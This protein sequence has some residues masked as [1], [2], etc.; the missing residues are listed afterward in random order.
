MDAE[1]KQI[2][3]EIKIVGS[4]A[5]TAQ[6]AALGQ[7]FASRT[8][9]AVIAAAMDGMSNEELLATGIALGEAWK[10]E[11][12]ASAAESQKWT[13][14]GM[15]ILVYGLTKGLGSLAL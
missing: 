8:P 12:A 15:R 7:Y 13:D 2:L 6:A 3:D 14:F 9:V 4:T 11:N 5:L 10:A 1:L